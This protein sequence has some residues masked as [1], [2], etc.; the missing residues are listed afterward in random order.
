MNDCEPY[1]NFKQARK[2]E[3][4]REGVRLFRGGEKAGGESGGEQ[5][6]S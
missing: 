1:L 3:D 6:K 2:L 5:P 4:R